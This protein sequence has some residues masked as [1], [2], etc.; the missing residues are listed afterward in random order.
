ME[1][2]PIYRGTRGL[3]LH[4]GD[5]TTKGRTVN[6]FFSVYNSIIEVSDWEQ[7]MLM[8]GCFEESVASGV[9]VYMGGSAIKC[10]YQHNN[11]HL[12]GSMKSGTY[13]LKE[14]PKGLWGEVDLPEHSLG[15]MIQVAMARGDLDEASIGFLPTAHEWIQ[16]AD[17]DMIKILKADLKEGSICNFPKNPAAKLSL[18][19]DMLPAEVALKTDVLRA[20]NRYQHNLDPT[21]HDRAVLEDNRAFIEPVLN[22]EMKEVLTKA[23]SPK[24]S[25]VV[26]VGLVVD[27]LHAHDLL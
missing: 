8:P 14:Q 26:P 24:R 12:L 15:D 25:P 4:A 7:M 23:L 13:R 6:G 20:L 1:P 11:E 3:Q 16:G 10:L 2:E 19:A 17:K 5:P 22:A 9:C 18:H 27:F 21:E